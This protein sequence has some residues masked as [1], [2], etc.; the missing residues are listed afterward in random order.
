MAGT[1]RRNRMHT[2]AGVAVPKVTPRSASDSR[3]PSAVHGEYGPPTSAP[4][5]LASGVRSRHGPNTMV[6]R[7]P[8]SRTPLVPGR[9]RSSRNARRPSALAGSAK[10]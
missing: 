2:P 3:T 5:T 1:G 8:S 6:S 7:S 9:T 4:A 10:S